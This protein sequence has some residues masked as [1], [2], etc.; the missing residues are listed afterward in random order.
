MSK[1][2]SDEGL[3]HLDDRYITS[4]MNTL[5]PSTQD[6]PAMHSAAFQII[7]RTYD[8]LFYLNEKLNGS[9]YDVSEFCGSKVFE[10]SDLPYHWPSTHRLDFASF[11][12][13]WD[14][15]KYHMSKERN[16]TQEDVERV[17]SSAILGLAYVGISQDE[18][19]HFM[20]QL[21]GVSRV[22]LYYLP[23]STNAEMLVFTATVNNLAG[24]HLKWTILFASVSQLISSLRKFRL[25]EE[26]VH[27]VIDLCMQ[28]ITTLIKLDVGADI[29]MLLMHAICT[30]IMTGDE[31]TIRVAVK[32]TLLAFV[33]RKM[34]RDPHP[35][36]D[37]EAFLCDLGAT[38]R[39]IFH[40]IEYDA[41]DGGKLVQEESR[42]GLR[43][44]HTQSERLSHAYTH[45][46][47][48]KC[49]GP[50]RLEGE[51]FIG[52]GTED[53]MPKESNPEADDIVQL[54]LS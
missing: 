23:K 10:Y 52:F 15:I 29:N 19:R 11:F 35:I 30:R 21:N 33:K 46:R 37:I 49:T 8:L 22:L 5:W 1:L 7:D 45:E 40:S 48:R 36:G 20:K 6:S 42:M 54:L 27:E 13:R 25:G 31:P 4:I 50:A 18:A 34:F 38:D 47:P 44:T 9:R 17:V 2:E 16:S 39:R 24:D 14:Y 43:L 32:E 26:S 28:V 53:A 51:N 3:I 41:N 12:G